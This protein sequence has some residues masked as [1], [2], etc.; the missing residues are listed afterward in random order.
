[1]KIAYFVHDVTDPAVGRRLGM[2]RA[3]GAEVEVIGFRR[4]DTATAELDG[5]HVFDLGRTYDAQLRDR[6]GRVLDWMLKVERFRA[7]VQGAQVFMARNLEMLAIASAARRLTQPRPVLAYECLDIHRLMLAKIGAGLRL[8]ERRLLAQ[9]RLLIVSS[10]AFLSRY[11]EPV[12]QI[13]RLGVKPLLI[14]NK[15]LDLTASRSAPAWAPRRPGPPWRIGWFGCLRCRK[16]LN[17]L[18]ALAARRPDLVEVVIRGRPSPAVFEDFADTV[19][20]VPGMLFGGPYHP[21]ETGALYR[22]CHFS[23]A[24]D[25]YDEGRNSAILIPNR[26]YDA[27]AHHCIPLALAGVET[28]RWLARRGVGVLLEDPLRELEAFFESLDA[29]GY[30]VLEARMAA[31]DPNEFRADRAEC[32]RIQSALVGVM[33]KPWF[34]DDPASD[35]KEYRARAPRRAL[36][37]RS[38]EPAGAAR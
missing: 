28:G 29:D 13:G 34:S 32:D 16:S 19:D 22:D 15:H 37:E 9:T 21:R 36:S 26:I 1:M 7:R 31:V 20:G 30:R 12:Q 14:E 2:L 27:G 38:G 23:W 35:P 17:L 24:I 3:M 11:F 4:S 6:A 18:T 10:P 5:A 25:Y 8:A 33:A